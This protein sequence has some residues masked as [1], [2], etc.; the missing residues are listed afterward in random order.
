L[1]EKTQRLYLNTIKVDSA[2]QTIGQ[3]DVVPDHNF[4]LSP[5][6][7]FIGKV[8]LKSDQQY[9]YFDGG[10]RIKH[11]CDTLLKRWVRFDAQINPYNVAIPITTDT[12][13]YLN[14]IRGDKLGMGMYL[15]NDSA[16]IY[17][18]FAQKKDEI[19]DHEVIAATGDL[20]FNKELQ[21]YI[22]QPK[23]DSML[24]FLPTGNVMIYDRAK[25]I[26]TGS[27]KVDLGT[28]LGQVQM[29]TYGIVTQNLTTKESN[30]SLT[31]LIDFFFDEDAMKIMSQILEAE[32]G[33]EGVNTGDDKYYSTLKFILGPQKG[34][35]MLNQLN[36]SG[37]M[38]DYPKDLAKWGFFFADVNMTWNPKTK[39]FVN[40]GKI[41]IA[42]LKDNQM[43]KYVT[44]YVEIA[45][46]RSGNILNLYL[47]SANQWFFFSYQNNKVQTI[48]SKKEYNDAIK[49]AMDDNKNILK[50]E[51]GEAN[52]AFIISTPKRKADFLKKVGAEGEPNPGDE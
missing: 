8:N 27:G 47:E 39:S 13:E 32:A 24:K 6:F 36:L 2:G 50:G 48:S 33:T 16:L 25:C 17:T 4:L 30:L 22:I 5:W 52:Y 31:M 12:R 38:K 9:L 35:E 42:S 23:V 46:K 14:G 20:T 37:H 7:G 10:A 43:Y 11:D 18:A 28:G 21:Q 34:D 15:G 49:K 41:G 19:N 3:G 1:L 51:K 45:R 44:G 26:A 40:D 29:D